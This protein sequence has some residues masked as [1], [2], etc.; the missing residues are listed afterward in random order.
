MRTLSNKRTF[1]KTCVDVVAGVFVMYVIYTGAWVFG[2]PDTPTNSMPIQIKLLVVDLFP[3]VFGLV[4]LIWRNVKMQNEDQ[5]I[6]NKWRRKVLFL[7]GIPYV[8]ILT[9]THLW[10]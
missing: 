9:L 4:W 5:E 1:F 2:Q 6:Q 10:R 3:A 7:S 8:L